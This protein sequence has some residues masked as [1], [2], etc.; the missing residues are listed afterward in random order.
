MSIRYLVPNLQVIASDLVLSQCDFN[1]YF[2]QY[3]QDIKG[4]LFICTIARADSIEGARNAI[5]F[6]QQKYSDA[7]HNCWAF[8]VDVP[9]STAKVGYSDDGEPHGTAGKPMLLQLQY[10]DI[11]ELVAVV[12]R[13]FGGTKLG[14]GGLVRAYQ[15]SVADALQSLPTTRK[16]EKNTIKITLDYN[17]SSLL[18]RIQ[19]RYELSIINE[20]FAT[21]ITYTIEIPTDKIDDFLKEVQSATNGNYLI[22]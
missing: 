20:Q 21:D 10:C 13:Y 8:Q 11:G 19:S 2:Y 14:T 1:E 4:S 15:G 9:K 18:H 22:T 12:T 7:T 17:Y 5:S 3:E 16:I 6:I